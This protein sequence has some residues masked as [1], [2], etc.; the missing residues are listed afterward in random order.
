M[1]KYLITGLAAVAISGMFT[2][3][4]H[5]TEAGGSSN[6][7][8]VETYEQAFISRFGTPS[9]DADWGFGN[10]ATQASTRANTRTI[11]PEHNF[12]NDAIAK[13]T[14]IT[15]STGMNNT[16][17]LTKIS[18]IPGEIL[19]Y[20]QVCQK[21]QEDNNWNYTPDEFSTGNCYI[22]ANYTGKVKIWS[23]NSIMYIE[24]NHDF[25]NG[26]TWDVGANMTVYL[27]KD[28]QLT[29]SNQIGG[30]SK[31]YI[32]DGAKLTI[33]NSVSTGNVSYY[34]KGG[35]IEV[36]SSMVVN[37]NNELFIEDGS[38]SVN[39]QLQIQYSNFYAK[40]TTLSVQ[41][42]D[43]KGDSFHF[44]N[45]EITYTYGNLSVDDTKF[46]IKDTDLSV[47]GNLNLISP[48]TFYNEGGTITC[49]GELKANSSKFYSSGN[50]QFSYI[51]AN[52]SGVIYNGANA[53]MTSTGQI[54]L[55][56]NNNDGTGSTLIN[57][58]DLVGTYLGTEGSALFQN[59]GNTTISGQT[60]LNSNSNTWVNNGQ[61]RT[62]YFFY[63]A[64]S[65]NVINN[66]HLTVDEDMCLNFGDG[67]SAFRMDSGSGVV[68]KNFYGGG[69]QNYYNAG[70]PFRVEMGSNSVF[71][72]TNTAQVIASKPYYGFYGPSEG[73]PA[74]LH[75]NKIVKGWDWAKQGWVVSYGGNLAV[76]VDESH[77]EQGHDGDPTHPF[78]GEE[79]DFKLATDLYYKQSDG[80]YKNSANT[81]SSIK[82]TPTNCN[83]G[84]TG[85]GGDTPTPEPDPEPFEA[86][87]RVIAEDMGDQS[88]N[89][90]SDFDFN[91]VVF[92]VTWVSES[93]VK[94]KILAA[95]GTLPLTV[96]WDGTEDPN[97][98]KAYIKHEVHYM[99]GYSESTMINT[100]TVGNYKDGVPPYEFE[101]T[102]S[103]SKANFAANV[104]DN[105][106][107]K[108][109]KNGVWYDI[110]ADQ[111]KAPGKI[112]VG[113]DYNPWCDE[114]VD[115]DDWWMDNDKKGLFIKYT[116]APA[117]L[118]KYWYR[119]AKFRRLQNKEIIKV[120]Y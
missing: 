82:I 7:G 114:R 33:K 28:A 79:D 17:F 106:P 37:G 111:G 112:A 18:D 78:I 80:T 120:Q 59:N 84:F 98:P 23:G 62:Q 41:N 48:T 72:V 66:C 36:T 55:T 113:T 19:S 69:T 47:P 6:L 4:T 16:N 65:R 67:N 49:T 46:Y 81:L 43:L 56:N 11:Q 26:R 70:G 76:A 96:G 116:Q 57:D 29:I 12:A 77:F 110:K 94:I 107:V 42:L 86:V 85:G 64:G 83:P 14:T 40:N 1:K 117:T 52:G 60:I 22:D 51:E 71:K 8:V 58:G 61:Y 53:T 30:G 99:L 39:G 34:V 74:V 10:G 115:V 109:R 21:I 50:S 38:L 15:T 73:A 75:A 92:D 90:A 63:S 3:C 88:L 24:G 108:V 54:K 9:A 119:Q 118:T 68:T 104:R 32:A 20:Q 101:F 100:H 97:D 5:D 13:P 45:G 87:V 103:F 105:I 35:D 44:E 95:G 89:E 93:K 102:G 25:T 31:V 2:S 91:D 27:L